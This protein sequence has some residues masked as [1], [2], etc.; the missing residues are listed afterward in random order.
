MPDKPGP[1]QFWGTPEE[2]IRK[3]AQIVLQIQGGET[4]A[5]RLVTLRPNEVTTEVLFNR[6]RLGFLVLF[7]AQDQASANELAAGTIWGTVE[8]GK[9]IINHAS[10]AT[11]RRVG[12]VLHG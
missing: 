6:A 12:I 7:S 11:E 4:N 8:E 5:C 2:G 10:A 3:L 1:P 9:V